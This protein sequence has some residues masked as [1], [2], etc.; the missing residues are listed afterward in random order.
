MANKQI[1][2]ET[3]M[4]STD[5]QLS[6][7]REVAYT[8]DVNSV[9][10]SFDIKDLVDLTAYT[11]NVLLYMR[12]GSFYQIT[13]GIVKTG[14]TVSYTL[15]GNEG[16]HN[17]MVRVQLILIDGTTELASAKHEFRI[18]AGLD[19]VVATEVMI[20]DWTTLTR[21]AREFLDAA[22]ADEQARQS[23]EQAR[24]VSEGQRETNET[25]RNQAESS[26][27]SAE[28]QRAINEQARIDDGVARNKELSDSRFSGYSGHTYDNLGQRLDT[29][30]SAGLTNAI[31]DFTNAPGSK[32][33]IAGTRENGFYGFVQPREFGRIESNPEL[34]QAFNGANLALN[35]GLSAGTSI[36]SETAWMKF[37]RRGEIYFVPVKPLRHSATWNAIYNQG[38]VYGTGGVG[39]NPPYGRAGHR[40]SVVNGA[41]TI[42]AAANDGFLR[43]GAV[44]GAVGQTIVTR[45]FSNAANNGEF[46]IQTITD[47]A[48]TVAAALVDEAG[49]PRASIYEKTRAVNQNRDVVVGGNRYR[50]QLLK[51]AAQDPLNSFADVDRDMVG[52]ESEWNHLILPMHERAKLQNWRFPTHAGTTEDW[53]IG[54]TD[55]DLITHYEFG[56]GSYTW[57]QETNDETPYRRVIRGFHGAS[58]GSHYPSWYEWNEIGWRPVLRLLS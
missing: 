9:Q 18:E 37:S 35:I 12:D 28:E 22:K 55:A 26:R 4:L 23:N 20:Q 49:A 44:L 7:Q 17:G 53:G 43:S 31:V 48:I 10:L 11:P 40:L 5:R 15:K 19:T 42:N 24:I 39:V 45:G 52:P 32:A 58:N 51:G 29:M 47:T 13:T 30:E 34:N 54:L 2:F 33:L 27:V 16:K 36:N 41:F 1:T 6:F 56:T 8:N 38:A 21:E 14:T 25:N 46:V 3:F 57:C 50:V